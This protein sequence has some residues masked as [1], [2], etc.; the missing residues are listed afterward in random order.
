[1]AIETTY[2]RY[3]HSHIW[4]IG[5]TLEPEA[6]KTWA[7]AFMQSIVLNDIKYFSDERFHLKSITRRV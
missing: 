2:M 6:L 5:I 1:M 4:I 7:Q 3:A